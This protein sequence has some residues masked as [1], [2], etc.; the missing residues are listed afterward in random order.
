MSRK[1]IYF[2][3]F[4]LVALSNLST[5]QAAN[6]EVFPW[7]NGKTSDGIAITE[8]KLSGFKKMGSQSGVQIADNKNDATLSFFANVPSGKTASLQYSV[9]LKSIP[10]QKGGTTGPIQ[11]AYTVKIGKQMVFR[12]TSNEGE[13]NYSLENVTIPSGRHK[14]SINATVIKAKKC[15]LA[16]CIDSLFIHVHDY[17]EMEVVTAPL[18]G[19]KGEGRSTCRICK[20]VN[21]VTLPS[22]YSK[23]EYEFYS[24]SKSSCMTSTDSVFVCKHCSRRDIHR[25][26]VRKDHSF[27]NEGVCQK[28]GLNVPP[29]KAGSGQT[30]YEIRNAAEM[31]V[32]A[33]LVSLGRISGNIGIDIVD[34]LVFSADIPMLPLGTADHPFQGVLN[35][36]GHRIRGISDVNEGFDGV[37]FIGV[38][39][40]LPQSNAVISNLIFDQGNSLQGASSVGG[41]VG[42]AKNCDIINCASFGTLEGT[43]YVGGIVG[44]ADRQV[45][46]QNCASVTTIRSS[47]KWNPVA[48]GMPDGHFMNSYGSA[49]KELDGPLDILPTAQCRH[50]FSTDGADTGLTH[51]TKDMLT[52]YSMVQ[53][54]NEQSETDCFTNSELY[55][56]PIPVVASHIQAKANAA[57]RTPRRAMSLRDL[58]PNSDD[59]EDVPLSDK[60]R[61]EVLTIGGYVNEVSPSFSTIEA[62]MKEDSVKYADF[63]RAYIATR[64]VPEGFQLYDMISGGDLMSFESCITPPDSS[65]TKMTE[66]DIVSSDYVMP[67]AETITYEAGE[68]ELTDQYL[69]ENNGTRRLK[70]RITCENEYNIICE[71]N[72]NGILKPVWRI[73]T[74][75]DNKGNAVSSQCYSF[76]NVTGESTLEYTITYDKPGEETVDPNYSEYLDEQTGLI[77]AIYTYLPE[78]DND[79]IYRMHFI[80]RASDLYPLEIHTEVMVDGE[81]MLEDG[82]YFLYSDDGDLLQYVAYG[83]ADEEPGVIRPYNYMEFL[84]SWE[85]TS[86]PTAIQIP[87]VDQPSKQKRMDNNVYDMQGRV[88]RQVTDLK[89]P[90]SGLPNG[91]YLYHGAKYLK[92]N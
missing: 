87:T 11:I 46:I 26:G 35:G 22:P 77:H 32:L 15:E 91:V 57:I 1:F 24:K 67:K 86:Y 52:S 90:F 42:F 30:V 48:C 69:L 81:A 37:G 33:E 2:F 65:Y 66:Y 92:R 16:G 27:N 54:L 45:T 62:I 3:V 6:K 60:E 83:P 12:R 88:V 13:L 44:Y 84:G 82:G 78:E 39:I 34:D 25:S 7:D 72:I 5:V 9:T 17:G 40:G 58:S 41:I 53:L 29:F 55:D 74:D 73:Q 51:V 4:L 8:M 36:H 20:K 76:N 14:I 89:D 80:I 75:Y 19:Q 61:G 56:Y 31:R 79:S 21:T 10:N 63:E 28:C 70:S 85:G 68:K 49:T 38:A 43:H 59:D 18:C 71:E 64:T 50:C 47:G 23:C